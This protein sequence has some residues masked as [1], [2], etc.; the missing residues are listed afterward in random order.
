M[1]KTEM[2]YRPFTN[3]L[4]H[5]KISLKAL[6]WIRTR[7]GLLLMLTCLLLSACWG[8][9][10]AA[11]AAAA[12]SGATAPV[13][14]LPTSATPANDVATPT[15]IAATATPAGIAALISTPAT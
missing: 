6:P 2:N 14:A 13:S 11:P 9:G 8:D 4:T 12:D 3:P 1:R 7:H 15:E 5:Y 10:E